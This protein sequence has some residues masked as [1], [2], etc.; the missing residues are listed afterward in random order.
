MD[1]RV[2]HLYIDEVHTENVII[3]FKE[4]LVVGLCTTCFKLPMSFASSAVG[5]LKQRLGQE[6]KGY[7]AANRAMVVVPST[8]AE[9]GYSAVAVW[10]NSM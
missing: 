6:P 7:H 8:I 9:G 5:P 2:V 1:V 10:V 3:N 4:A